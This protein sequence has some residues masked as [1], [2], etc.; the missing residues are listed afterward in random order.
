A[1]GPHPPLAPPAR[2]TP[3]PR[4]VWSAAGAARGGVAAPAPAT[5]ET[6]LDLAGTAA[7][8]SERTAAPIACYLVGLAGAS[9]TQAGRTAE[10]IAPPQPTA[11]T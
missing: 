5:I 7:H 2:T 9:P 10:T 6:L 3:A 1:C 8:A 11:G 4:E